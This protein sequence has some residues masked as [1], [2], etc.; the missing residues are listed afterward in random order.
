ML[1]YSPAKPFEARPP[2]PGLGG[3]RLKGESMKFSRLSN[4]ATPILNVNAN[5]P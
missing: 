5:D 2:G 1:Y 4:C 3:A